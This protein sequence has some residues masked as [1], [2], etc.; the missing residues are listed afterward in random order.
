MHLSYMEIVGTD[1]I[2]I[3]KRY[4]D[5][6][7][8]EFKRVGLDLNNVNTLEG[9]NAHYLSYHQRNLDPKYCQKGET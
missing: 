9:L 1:R 5:A 7:N 3:Y 8:D 2:A 4:V 6:Y